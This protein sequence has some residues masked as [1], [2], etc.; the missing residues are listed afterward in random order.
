MYYAVP[1]KFTKEIIADASYNIFLNKTNDWAGLTWTISM[2]YWF[3]AF[4]FILARIVTNLNIRAA[5]VL[6]ICLVAHERQYLQ[7][8]NVHWFSWN[9]FTLL[10][11]LVTFFATHGARV[12]NHDFDYIVGGS[13]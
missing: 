12:C 11:F 13:L 1:T 10:Y 7:L 2:E 9:K 6:F 3:S 8:S 5:F 4:V